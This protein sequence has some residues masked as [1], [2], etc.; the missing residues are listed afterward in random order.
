MFAS[1]NVEMVLQDELRDMHTSSA[2]I[3]E[4]PV[5]RLQQLMS[6]QLT[7]TD[8]LLSTLDIN[9]IFQ[10]VHHS[11]LACSLNFS[12]RYFR[13]QMIVKWLRAKSVLTSGGTVQ[14]LK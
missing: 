2:Y 8:K 14:E 5:E 7:I 13:P 6:S 9:C 12:G 4:I 3:T 11:G 10:A 1:E